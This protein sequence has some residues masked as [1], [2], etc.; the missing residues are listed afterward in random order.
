MI[1]VGIIGLGGIAKGLHIPQ[2][3]N[4]GKFFIKA[5]ADIQENNP[6][7][8]G[9]N[10]PD[11]YTDYRKML[12]DPEIEAVL[13]L[14]PHDCH[15]E[16]CVAAFNA[17][18]HVLIEKPIARN[19]KEAN[20][21]MDAHKKSGKIGMIGFCQ[22]FY[23][24]HAYIKSIIDEGKLGQL[25]SARV[26]HYQNFNRQASSWWRNTE[27]V[28]GGAVIGSGVHRLDLLRWFM[29]DVKTVYA[30]AAYMPERLEAEACVHAVIEFKSGAVANFSINWAA[31]NYMH[32][33]GI[34]VS[35]KDG[36]VVTKTP[37]GIFK[38]GLK[39]DDKGILKDSEVPR[40][41]SMYEHF[42]ECIEENKEP[43]PSLDE[44]YK[45][46]QL[47]RAIY[48]SIETGLPVNPE[49]IDL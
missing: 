13:V 9:L 48:K 25:L 26:D 7:F 24:E 46:L 23:A 17:G 29:G 22:R 41:Q 40:C 6:F 27:K 8:E 15:E 18:K 3:Q 16:H 10:I 30:K 12:E 35:G 47:V 14:S 49:E 44:G 5:V 2:L 33:E 45:T 21:I 43:L 20:A 38:I 32:A 19:L 11:Y 28:G 34:S 37:G 31:Y 39:D 1:N 42:A 4:T 36:L